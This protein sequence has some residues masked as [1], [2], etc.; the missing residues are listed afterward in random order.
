MKT[1]SFLLLSALLLCFACQTNDDFE[2]DNIAVEKTVNEI[3]TRGAGAPGGIPTAEENR[4][5]FESM[6]QWTAYLTAQVL[7]HDADAESEFVNVL[8]NGGNVPT[9]II[10]L[11]DLLGGDVGNPAFK[12]A[13][14]EQFF[15]FVD[16][17]CGDWPGIILGPIEG[18]P[19]PHPPVDVADPF[20]CDEAF[21][22]FIY[23]ILEANCLEIYLPLD[24]DEDNNN[25]TSTAHP[26]TLSN[27]NDCYIHPHDNNMPEDISMSNIYEKDN[28]IMVR[29]VRVYGPMFDCMY[30]EYVGIDFTLFLDN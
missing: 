12:R 7:Y 19:K 21:T 26:L 20:S 5:A 4:A 14:K 9:K 10:D 1:N 3:N 30:P 13:F 22:N 18:S 11:S 17:D 25:F 29:P 2:S 16:I 24:Y 28:P 8:N 6:M 23:A 27:K 15:R